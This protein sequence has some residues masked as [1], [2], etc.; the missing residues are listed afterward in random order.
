[1]WHA[2]RLIREEVG[3]VSNTKFMEVFSLHKVSRYTVYMY[4]YVDINFSIAIVKY[5]V[6]AAI[7]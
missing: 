3:S 5:E 4:M 7:H 6:H 2:A 1:M